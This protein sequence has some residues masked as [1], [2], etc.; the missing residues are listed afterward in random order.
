MT[1]IMTG[2]VATDFICLYIAPDIELAILHAS[3]LV[4]IP[5]DGTCP[6]QP[7]HEV[8]EVSHQFPA[9]HNSIIIQEIMIHIFELIYCQP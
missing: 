8:A 3:S 5:G 6:T 1:T 4:V 2:L 7:E 9:A